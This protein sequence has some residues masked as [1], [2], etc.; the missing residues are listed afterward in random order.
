MDI[1]DAKLPLVCIREG[2]RETAERDLLLPSWEIDYFV[3]FYL[4][5]YLFFII[6]FKIEV[7]VVNI[8]NYYCGS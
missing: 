6:I 2:D 3:S 4:S 7:V 1:L 5:I 8:H